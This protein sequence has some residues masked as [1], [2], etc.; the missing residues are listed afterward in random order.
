MGLIVADT[1]RM[2]LA[3]AQNIFGAERELQRGD[4][5]RLAGDFVKAY[6]AYRSAYTEAIK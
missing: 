2:H 1:I 3:A 4:A 5:L 6:E